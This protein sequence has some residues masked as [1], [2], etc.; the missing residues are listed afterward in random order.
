MN[1]TQRKRLIEQHPCLSKDAHHKYS[2]VHFS[3][4]PAC[5]VQCRYCIRKFDCVNESRPGVTSRILNPDEAIS[6]LRLLEGRNHSMRVVGIAGPGDPLANPSTFEFLRMVGREFPDYITCVS[7]NG[8]Y[9]NESLPYLIESGVRSVTVT[10]SAVT[11]QTADRIYAWI[12]KDG[13]RHSGVEAMELLVQ[14][15]WQGLI[16][17]INAGMIVK[18]NTIYIP[19][20]NEDEMPLIARRAGD[21]GAEVQNIMPLIPQ[22]EFAHLKRPG[23]DEMDRMR[24]LCGGHIRQ[25]THCTQCRAD[26]FGKLGEDGDMELEVVNAEL[27]EDYCE[28]VC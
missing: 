1:E 4:A 28:S 19:G 24:Y 12:T 26:A 27:G 7:T 15:Q 9:L 13:K 8:L 21:A 22:S 25:M 23:C 11:S 5:N 2:R 3:V 17:A 14:A 10:I 6:R 20:V 18:V 16:R